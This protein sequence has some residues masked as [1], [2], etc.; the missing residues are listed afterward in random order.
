MNSLP[1]SSSSPGVEDGTE[2]A[3]TCGS[4]V[5]GLS[6]MV[7]METTVVLSG[8]YGSILV[9]TQSA[10]FFVAA[11]WGGREAAI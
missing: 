1:S 8:G 3:V 6:R 5:L 7:A 4:A 2:S 9:G 10:I 11:C